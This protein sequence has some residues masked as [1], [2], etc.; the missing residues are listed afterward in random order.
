MSQ[1]DAKYL[2]IGAEHASVT[3]GQPMHACMARL[4]LL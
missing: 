4:K 2:I 1:L 3:L